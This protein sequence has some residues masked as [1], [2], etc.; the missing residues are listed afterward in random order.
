MWTYEHS[1]ETTAEPS[2]VY[3]LMRDVASWPVWNA[4]VE[5]I[6]L[7][8]PFAAGTSGRMAMPGQESIEFRLVWVEADRGFE[9]ETPLPD[10]GVT[11][12]VRHQLA[13]LGRGGTRI[14]YRCS[15]SGPAA[16]TA[17]A[18]IGL[19]VTGDFPQ[20]LAALAARAE[21]AAVAG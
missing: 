10:A 15:I 1:V 3:S 20:V 2:A 4:G 13:P 21:G 18:E 16:G 7:D 19:A 9:D 8:G 6:D 12:H 5:R 14:T 11:V 17:G